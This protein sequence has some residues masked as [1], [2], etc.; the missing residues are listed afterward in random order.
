MVVWQLL[1]VQCWAPAIPLTLDE[2]AGT[3]FRNGEVYR[4]IVQHLLRHGGTGGLS[5][6]KEDGWGMCTM[7]DEGVREEV[8]ADPCEDPNHQPTMTMLP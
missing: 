1:F 2:S 3:I 4:G 5:L 7:T 8:R 6:N